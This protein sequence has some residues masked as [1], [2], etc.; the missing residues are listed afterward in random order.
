MQIKQNTP[1]LELTLFTKCIPVCHCRYKCVSRK[2]E[3]MK[4]K[5]MTRHTVH[6]WLLLLTST[7]FQDIIHLECLLVYILYLKTANHPCTSQVKTW[8]YHQFLMCRYQYKSVLLE[9]NNFPWRI[10]IARISFKVFI[11]SNYPQI[12]QM[13]LP[14][15]IVPQFSSPFCLPHFDFFMLY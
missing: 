14:Y 9:N 11:Y 15:F 7:T 10:H 6:S 3:S 8:L 13:Y 2:Y 1:V 12:Q 4:D 5:Q